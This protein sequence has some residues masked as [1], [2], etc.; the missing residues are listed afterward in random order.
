MKKKIIFILPLQKYYFFINEIFIK[1]QIINIDGRFSKE[2]QSQYMSLICRNFSWMVIQ[3]G[4]HQDCIVMSCT[5]NVVC[6]EKVLKIFIID[7]V[8]GND[9]C[10]LSR[11]LY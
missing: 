1:M 10:Y 9:I 7:S 8:G 4:T 2:G 5:A 3:K 6:Y 11:K